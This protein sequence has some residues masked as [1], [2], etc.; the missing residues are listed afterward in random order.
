MAEAADYPV[1]PELA[2]PHCKDEDLHEGGV[3]LGGLVTANPFFVLARERMG[4]FNGCEVLWT[5]NDANWLPSINFSFSSG[6][7]HL[8]R[9][10][11]GGISERLFWFGEAPTLDAARAVLK[12]RAGDTVD[13]KVPP[14]AGRPGAKE[15]M[16]QSW[17]D[18][19]K[20][21]A[22]SVWTH[23]SPAVANG[24]REVAISPIY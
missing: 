7:F 1:P 20:R 17:T 9:D 8:A 24:M 6:S 2:Q 4:P 22:Y 21:F 5:Q 16:R 14:T 19:Q 11:R 23:D 3:G 18:R 12:K 15:G 13:W 10:A